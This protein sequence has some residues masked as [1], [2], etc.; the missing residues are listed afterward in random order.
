ML[1]RFHPPAHLPKGPISRPSFPRTLERM[2]QRLLPGEILGLGH[3]ASFGLVLDLDGVPSATAPSTDRAASRL[4]L[5]PQT[6]RAAAEA[7]SSA[8]VAL[9]T[10]P[11]PNQATPTRPPPTSTPT[12]L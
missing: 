5:Q 1:F 10:R 2:E 6:G 4:V 12:P 7:S 8:V 9:P 3:L 11:S